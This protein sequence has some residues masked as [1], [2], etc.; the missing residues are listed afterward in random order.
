[1]VGN[2][3]P[4]LAKKTKAFPRNLTLSPEV[5]SLKVFSGCLFLFAI[6]ASDRKDAMMR[7]GL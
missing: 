7:C 2:M 3:K 4:P 6:V 5:M 1:M